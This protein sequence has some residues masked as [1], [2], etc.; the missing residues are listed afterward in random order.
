[1]RLI[2]K[3]VANPALAIGGLLLAVIL[4]LT[5]AAG[6]F[7]PTNPLNM[8]SRPFLA[9]GADLRWPLGTDSMGRDILAGILYGGRVSVLVGTVSTLIG[10][11]IGLL[12][13][14]L[15][16]Y[17][18]GRADQLL[19]RLIEIFQTFPPFLLVIVLIAV[20]QPSVATITLSIGLV[21][22]PAI[23]RI[24]RSEFRVLKNL[25]FVQAARVAGYGD[26]SIATGQILPNAIA[27][28][29]V[30]SSVMVASAILIESALSFLGLGDPNT[31][32]WG[33]MIGSGRDQLRTAWY[34][35]TL[36]GLAIVV[37]VLSLNLL[38]DGLARAL[39]PR[40]D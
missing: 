8:V 17:F 11:V 19:V 4:G 34:V 27:P 12:V 26:F 31:V 24:V 7:Y 28:I 23:A 6:Q 37:T 1:M 30:T 14:S 39:N 20:F 16:G 9:P 10:L 21:S 38:T 29:I 36:P 2:R 22:W 3:A 33:S 15:A 32:S 25:D 35:I 13:G 18:G 5:V 40:K